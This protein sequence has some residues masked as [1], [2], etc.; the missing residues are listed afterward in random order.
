MQLSDDMLALLKGFEGYRAAPYFDSAGKKTIGFGHLIK[1]GENFT[2][3]NINDATDLLRKDIEKAVKGVNTLLTTLVPE[4]HQFDAMV[5]FAFNV[6]LTNLAHSTLLKLV[7]QEKYDLATQ[8]F[9]KW[10]HAIVDGKPLII[11][12]L[13]RRRMCEAIVFD[14][15]SYSDAAKYWKECTK[16]KEMK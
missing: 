4:Q 11:E 16:L 3:L 8:E 1:V 14:T 13:L 7:L 12:G 9:K 10:C 2:S 15:G 5:A 6:G